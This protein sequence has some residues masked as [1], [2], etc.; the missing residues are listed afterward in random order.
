MAILGHF[1]DRPDVLE[2][3]HKEGAW[4]NTFHA[5]WDVLC[6]LGRIVYQ[7]A[8]DH[9]RAIREVLG[10][11]EFF[12]EQTPRLKAKEAARLVR[13]CRLGAVQE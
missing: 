3:W 1:Q 11:A 5:R 12:Y 8:D 4:A 9:D 13:A 6:E 7:C 10:F 2:L